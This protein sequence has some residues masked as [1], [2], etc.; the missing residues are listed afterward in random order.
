M[1]R[2]LFLSFPVLSCKKFSILLEFAILFFD[3]M[4]YNGIRMFAQFALS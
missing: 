2:P 4:W 1:S 3:K